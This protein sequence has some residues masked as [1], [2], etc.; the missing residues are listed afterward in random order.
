MAVYLSNCH[1]GNGLVLTNTANNYSGGTF[2]N[3][4]DLILGNGTV[5]GMVTGQIESED[6]DQVFF[7]VAAGTRKTFTGYIMRSDTTPG[8][9]NDCNVNKEGGGTLY[10]NPS[11]IDSTNCDS[12]DGTAVTGGIMVVQ[13]ANAIPGGTTVDRHRRRRAG[14]RR[15]DGHDPGRGHEPA[16]RRDRQRY[17]KRGL[18]QPIELVLR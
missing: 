13:N 5:N 14:P 8:D 15:H 17:V 2:L 12:Y 3:D 1:Q 16:R 4:G 6:V 18:R 10:F 11:Y 9:G 7:N